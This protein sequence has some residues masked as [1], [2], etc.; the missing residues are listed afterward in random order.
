MP[1]TM[2]GVSIA[3]GR[4]RSR[5]TLAAAVLAG[6]SLVL[7]APATLALTA[8]VG[9]HIHGFVASQDG[10]RLPGV[11][12]TF[13]QAGIPSEIR[14]TGDLAPLPLPALD[15]M[16]LPGVST[17]AYREDQAAEVRLASGDLGLYQSPDL[18]PGL[19]DVRAELAGF[20]TREVRAVEVEAGCGSPLDVVL[21][22]AAVEEPVALAAAA[23][24]D[25][26]EAP[27]IRESGARDVGEL[28]DSVTGVARVRKGGIGNDI[29]LRGL[30]ARD[31]SVL[32]DGQRLHGACPYRMDPAVFHFD[33]A[34]VERVE[35]GRG[36]F[37]MR[38]QGSLS[39][40]V[41]VVTRA[42]E[43]GWRVAPQ[44]SLG[45][46]RFVNPSLTLARGT[47][48]VSALAGLSWRRSDVYRDGAGR[49]FTAAANYR[50][51]A[52]SGEAFGIGTAWGRVVVAPGE[53]QRIDLSYAGQRSDAVYSPY[54]AMDAGSDHMDRA[55]LRYVSD[56]E[57]V[58]VTAQAYW[59]RV[60]HWMDDRLRA[61][62]VGAERGYSMR[63]TARTRTWGGRLQLAHGGTTAGVEGYVRSWD[64]A[65]ET[66]DMLYRPQPMVPDVSVK[67]LGLFVEHDR[68]LLSGWRLELGARLDHAWSAA[69][70]S[71][72]DTALY[73]AYQA[74]RSTSA[75][76]TLPSAK[77]RLRWRRGG[78][79][80]AAGLG[81]AERFPAPDE[82]YLALHREGADWV[83]DPSL[84]RS[85]NTD[86]DL[87]LSWETRGARATLSLFQAWVG[88]YVAVVPAARIVQVPDVTNAEARSF[89]NV[90]ATL[91]G[92]ELAT[93]L[94][95]GSRLF[96]TGELAYT[97]GSKAADPARGIAA[98]P[99]AEMPPLAG[100]AG[101][102]FDDGRVFATLEGS[103]AGRQGRVD[104]SLREQPTA[105]WATANVRAGV[106]WGKTM[107]TAGVE[108]L[109]DLDYVEHLSYQRD[110]F[111]TGV[112]VPEPGR[113]AYLRIS[114]RF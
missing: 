18:A 41:N 47:D 96:L 80:A 54:L 88:D 33:L 9:G 55:N 67:V 90:D 40:T 102:R 87:S 71:K 31:L 2:P 30:Q 8:E 74:T 108:N 68:T 23:P 45:S 65:N 59:A 63:T 83:G 109:F 26:L 4:V 39:G 10:A 106:R 17:A 57:A 70:G 66:A 52:G 3:G 113:N 75:Q 5:R 43:R 21:I 92:G 64:A 86:V 6:S 36:P 38:S 101:L 24:R 53:G 97:R 110:P 34:E 107:A 14:L 15:R 69:D 82:R 99:L 93:S 95:L 114:M 104:A 42:P 37:D 84:V 61:S 56:G 44:L 29:V 58:R 76:D 94:A 62:S 73:E 49:P 25:S 11:T 79:E 12:L 22:A 78:F 103:F 50:P 60:D 100:R 111:A 85:R 27:R 48:R 77:A 72:A 28:L 91:R 105:G 20:V 32:V 19:W 51:T 98:G 46:F 112:R 89:A 35:V 7:L 81:H 1:S 13:R 16:L